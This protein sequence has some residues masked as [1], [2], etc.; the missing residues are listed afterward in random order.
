MKSRTTQR[1]RILRLLEENSNQWVPSYRLAEIALQYG[2][3]VLELRRAGYRIENKLQDVDGETHGA[4]RLVPAA[5]QANLFDAGLD[6]RP[7]TPDHWLE[8]QPRRSL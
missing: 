1:G 5:S 7:P 4:F 2:A 3:R 6:A 8:A